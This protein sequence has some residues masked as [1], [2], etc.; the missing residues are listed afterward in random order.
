MW[1]I[2]CLPLSATPIPFLRSCGLLSLTV[3]WQGWCIP[4]WVDVLVWQEEKQITLLLSPPRPSVSCFHCTDGWREI[5]LHIVSSEP[6]I[7]KGLVLKAD[8]ESSD[9]RGSV[10]SLRELVGVAVPQ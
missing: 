8:L 6:S 1:L 10:R 9:W 3:L 4:L 7:W 2:S 5:Q